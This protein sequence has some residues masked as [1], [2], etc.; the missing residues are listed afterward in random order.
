MS[1]QGR[2]LV[3]ASESS[4]REACRRAL[5]PAGYV[6]EAAATG[7]EGMR[8]VHEAQ[9]DLVLLG[10]MMPDALGLELLSTI[11]GHDPD[12]VCIVITRHV[13]VEQAIQAIRAG[14]YDLVSEPFTASLLVT[15]VGQGLEKR[16]LALEDRRRQVSEQEAA[17]SARAGAELERL[18]RFKA[19]FIRVAAHQLRSP[20]TAIQSLLTTLIKGYAAPDQQQDFLQRAFDRSKDLL[21]MVDDLVS[22]AAVSAEQEGKPREILPL[23]DVLNQVLPLLQAEAG[24]KQITCIAEIR[25]PAKVK[26]HPEQMSQ[27]WINLISN[28]IQYTPSGGQVRIR[29]EVK[30]Q[31][32]VG[33]VEDTGIGIAAEYQSQIFEEFYRTPQAKEMKPRGTGLGL[34]LVKQIVEGHNG[35]IEVESAPGQGSRFTFRLPLAALPSDQ[36]PGFG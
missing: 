28:A 26:A 11:H 31:W 9:F 17:E 19:A 34:P 10:P 6:V 1:A 14:A 32:A 16:R 30:D 2:V 5:A 25:Q 35:I 4:D 29:L 18:E 22:L 24:E 20:V 36:G 12:M 8:L 27:L 3:V 7:Q 21:N 33:T 23:A 15:A 13:T